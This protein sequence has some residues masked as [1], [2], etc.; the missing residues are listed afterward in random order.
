MQNTYLSRA[1]AVVP[2]GPIAVTTLKSPRAGRYHEQDG[3]MRICLQNR[4]VS[5]PLPPSHAAAPKAD[6]AMSRMYVPTL[7]QRR[8]A[9][10]GCLFLTLA[11]CKTWNKSV[12]MLMPASSLMSPYMGGCCRLRE[13]RLPGPRIIIINII[14]YGCAHVSA[15]GW[16]VGEGLSWLGSED[17]TRSPVFRPG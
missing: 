17:P 7:T 6:T 8:P 2:S 3:K 14:M 10:R 12:M 16:A 1:R 9:R 15:M 4:H 5:S 13:C 11:R